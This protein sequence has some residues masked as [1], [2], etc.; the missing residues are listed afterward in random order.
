M[1]IFPRRCNRRCS[2]I[3]A[4]RENYGENSYGTDIGYTVKLRIEGTARRAKR[5]HIFYVFTTFMIYFIHLRFS[6]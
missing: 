3:R 5:A 2:A 6:Q 1:N 4:I